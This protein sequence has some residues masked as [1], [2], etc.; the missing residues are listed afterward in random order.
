MERLEWCTPCKVPAAERL[1]D[2]SDGRLAVVNEGQ[3]E[4]SVVDALIFDARDER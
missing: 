1:G 4:M 3:R 2:V